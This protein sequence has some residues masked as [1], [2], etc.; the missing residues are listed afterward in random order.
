[1]SKPVDKLLN[2][3]TIPT[4]GRIVH[5]YDPRFG[6]EHGGGVGK[7]PYPAMILKVTPPTGEISLRLHLRVSVWGNDRWESF[8]L[9]KGSKF[10]ATDMP[11]WEWPPRV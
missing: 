8:L 9:E 4:V 1:M 11:Y 5:Y 3:L 10:L 2:P 6:A 7:G